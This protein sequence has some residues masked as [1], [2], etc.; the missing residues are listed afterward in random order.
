MTVSKTSKISTAGGIFHHGIYND[1]VSLQKLSV[2]RA[3]TR[4]EHPVQ[5]Q[6]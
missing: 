3:R 5:W 4:K 6:S 2:V 1:T